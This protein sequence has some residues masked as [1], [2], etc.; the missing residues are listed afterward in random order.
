MG[1]WDKVRFPIPLPTPAP[2][3]QFTINHLRFLVFALAFVLGVADLPPLLFAG[4]LAPVGDGAFVGCNLTGPGAVVGAGAARELVS[5][6]TGI[7]ID[8]M[9]GSSA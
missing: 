2:F 1:S 5:A 6:F 9:V 8:A 4:V 3:L 7:G